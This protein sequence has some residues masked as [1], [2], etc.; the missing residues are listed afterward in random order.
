MFLNYLT[1]ISLRRYVDDVVL[2][3][4]IQKLFPFLLNPDQLSSRSDPRSGSWSDGVGFNF[5]AD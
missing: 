2:A 3:E 1:I 5:L 4:V